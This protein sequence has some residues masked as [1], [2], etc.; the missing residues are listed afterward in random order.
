MLGL[1]VTALIAGGWW[2]IGG[3]G[4]RRLNSVLDDRMGPS[5]AS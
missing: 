1:A 5:T 2:F 3:E 4:E